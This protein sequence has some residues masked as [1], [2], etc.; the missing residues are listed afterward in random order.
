V[1]GAEPPTLGAVAG[2][3]HERTTLAWERTAFSLM[4]IGVILGRFAAVNELWLAEP[5]AMALVVLGAGLLVWAAAFY[6]RRGPAIELGHD[7][8]HPAATRLVG[9]VVLT[10][11]GASL[12]AGLAVVGRDLGWFA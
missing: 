10:A 8:A 11:C 6:E 7:V 12:V 2:L 9:V 3:Q 1:S 5:L 4:G